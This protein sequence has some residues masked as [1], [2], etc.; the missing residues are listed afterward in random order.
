MRALICSW[1][2]VCSVLAHANYENINASAY[3]DDFISVPLPGYPISTFRTNLRYPYT[4]INAQSNTRATCKR[5]RDDDYYILTR[6]ALESK[7]T[8][9]PLQHYL[10]HVGI[11]SIFADFASN[12]HFSCLPR[13]KYLMSECDA[14]RF[15]RSHSCSTH[16]LFAQVRHF[17]PRFLR[18]SVF[19][20]GYCINLL[21]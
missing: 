10:L 16:N 19:I 3:C 13:H 7:Y 15:V 20:S 11:F 2:F 18:E 4:H 8:H 9:T 6:I 1:H 12:S 17:T 21:I 14:N 5:L